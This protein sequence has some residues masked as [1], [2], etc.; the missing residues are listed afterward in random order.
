MQEFQRLDKGLED[1]RSQIYSEL[2]NQLEI[3]VSAPTYNQA[4]VDEL[5]SK[6]LITKIDA[7]TMSGWE[8]IIR[9]THYGKTYPTQLK[10]YKKAKRNHAIIE[11]VK[12]LIPTII[13][14]IA[15]VVSILK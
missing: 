12:F 2:G 8:Y 3:N 13:S 4:Q 9:P 10:E 5:V 11:W 15:L 14:I 1:V 7:S 6:G